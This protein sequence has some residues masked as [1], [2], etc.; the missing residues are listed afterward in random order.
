MTLMVTQFKNQTI[1]ISDSQINSLK[2]ELQNIKASIDNKTLP[3]TIKEEVLK[4]KTTS[5]SLKEKGKRP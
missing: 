2:T 5:V 3:I 4:D 1:S